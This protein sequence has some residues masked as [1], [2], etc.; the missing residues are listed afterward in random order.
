MGEFDG[1]RVSVEVLEA[2]RRRAVALL[3]SGMAQRQVALVLGVHWNTVGRWLGVALLQR[4]ADRRLVALQRAAQRLLQRKAPAA[5]IAADAGQG[6]VDAGA[7][8]DQLLH[9]LAGSKGERQLQLIGALVADQALDRRRLGRLEPQLLV[10]SPAPLAARQRVTAP[11]K[12]RLRSYLTVDQQNTAR[13]MTFISAP[14][15]LL[16]A[17]KAAG[18]AKCLQRALQL[19][20][21]W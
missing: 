8:G 3:R 18:E 12:R 11:A 21:R 5:Q 19:I 6:E 10:R 20:A 4:A 7:A 2:L 15:S 9:R 1:R 13:A 14:C 16:F 17:V